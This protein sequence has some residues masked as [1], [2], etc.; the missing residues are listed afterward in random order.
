VRVVATHLS[1][2]VS[3]YRCSVDT[4]AST[5]SWW[6]EDGED[7]DQAVDC[8]CKQQPLGPVFTPTQLRLLP[9]CDE[10]QNRG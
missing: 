7:E 8:A 3:A 6:V 10:A 1:Y 5:V 4:G 2:P 9:C